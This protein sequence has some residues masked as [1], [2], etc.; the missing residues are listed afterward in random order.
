MNDE[1]KAA[2]ERAYQRCDDF[3]DA[4]LIRAHIRTSAQRREAAIAALGDHK[5]GCEGR[6]YT[7]TCGYDDALIRAHIAS[8]DNAHDAGYAAA[9]ADVVAWLWKSA[10]QDRLGDDGSEDTTNLLVAA[11]CAETVANFIEAGAH[12]GAAKGGDE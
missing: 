4:A 11:V 2:L 6:V 8:E 3:D 10:A 1:T 9:V 12:V 5:R 7:C